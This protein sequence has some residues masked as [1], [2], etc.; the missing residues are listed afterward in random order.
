MQNFAASGFSAEHFWQSINHQRT[1]RLAH[2]LS[3]YIA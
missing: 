2:S 1:K 3:S